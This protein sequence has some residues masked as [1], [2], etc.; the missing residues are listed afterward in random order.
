MFLDVPTDTLSSAGEWSMLK[1]ALADA[2]PELS[3]ALGLS[4]MLDGKLDVDSLSLHSIEV[5]ADR[6]SPEALS[7]LA[8]CYEKGIMVRKDLVSAAAQYIR[9]IRMDSPRSLQLLWRLVQEKGF[10]QEL[11]K[12]AEEDEPEAEFALAGIAA[13]GLDA[14]LSQGQAF[15]TGD[16]ALHFLR[17]AVAKGYPPALIELGLCYYAG[18]WVPRDLEKA[19]ACW[20]E[21]AGSGNR[22]AQ[23]RLAVV[24]VQDA[25]D[26]AA[27]AGA[28]AVLARGSQEGSILAEVALGYCYET[29]RGVSK[30]I[31]TAARLYTNGAS[32][33][34]QDAYRALRRMLDAIRPSDSEFRIDDFALQQ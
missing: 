26:P 17:K 24:T 3:A 14:L 18:R 4:R 11:K 2:G 28:L 23:I 31:A 5:A 15:V 8:R 19:V 12:R 7:V 27:L 20:N 34:S 16:Q 25:G 32:R 21:A 30:S 29:G 22:E 6:G 10:A 13:L 9:A 1:S 33:G